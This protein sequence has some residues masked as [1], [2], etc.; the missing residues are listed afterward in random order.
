MSDYAEGGFIPADPDDVAYEAE[1][2]RLE[3]EA[4]G[5][6]QPRGAW[7]NVDPAPFIDGWYNRDSG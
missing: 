6:P 7:E 2:A 1:V 3:Q 5:S 4:Y